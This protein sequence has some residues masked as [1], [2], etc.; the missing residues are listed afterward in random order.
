MIP[1]TSTPEITETRRLL[2][3]LPEQ[4]N[5]A[6]NEYTAKKQAHAMAKALYEF[7]FANVQNVE[8]MKDSEKTQ[9]D[10]ESLAKLACHQ[11]R[12]DMITAKAAED[13]ASNKIKFISDKFEAVLEDHRTHRAE[14][15]NFQVTHG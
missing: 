8:K 10:L 7:T 12:I 3:E 9:T 2:E 13:F 11:L 14:I 5:D 1:P 6:R 4:L 15:R